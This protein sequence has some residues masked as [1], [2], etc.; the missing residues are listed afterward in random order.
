[1]L[2]AT[3]RSRGS[4]MVALQENPATPVPTSETQP[5]VSRWLPCDVPADTRPAANTHDTTLTGCEGRAGNVGLSPSTGLLSR[6]H[7]GRQTLIPR[8]AGGGSEIQAPARLACGSHTANCSWHRQW[9]GRCLRCLF[10]FL[11]GR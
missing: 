6:R 3:G 10:L 7:P 11:Q 9:A 8:G 2:L 5:A 4:F 1:M